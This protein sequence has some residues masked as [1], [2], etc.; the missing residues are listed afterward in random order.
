M[1]AVDPTSGPRLRLQRRLDYVFEDAQLLDRA[2]THRSL[3]GAD[4]Y[5]RLEFLGDAVL[6]AVVA[7]ALFERF[8]GARESELTWARVQLVREASLAELA[9]GL[10]LGACIRVGRSARANGGGWQE[11]ILADSL[12]SLIGAAYVESGFESA[13]R[14]V[15]EVFAERLADPNLTR[16]QRDAKTRLQEL[17]QAR[18]RELPEYELVAESG[19]AHARSFEVCCRVTPLALETRASG[20]SRRKAEQAAAAAMIERICADGERPVDD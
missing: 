3:E 19:A 14:I 17:T 10:E 12:E 8:P 9:R 1:A 6:G 18:I 20:S 15:R 7:A 11:S 2:L 4:N 13:S 5:E 16:R